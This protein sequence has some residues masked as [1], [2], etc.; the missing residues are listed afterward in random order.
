MPSPFYL[1]PLCPVVSTHPSHPLACP[2]VRLCSLPLSLPKLIPHP[3]TP[4]SLTPSPPCLPCFPLF[5]LIPL[6]PALPSPSLPRSNLINFIA[7][8]QI[9]LASLMDYCLMGVVFAR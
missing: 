3:L 6:L 9:I 5:T 7:M 2:S 1:N 8:L 4:A